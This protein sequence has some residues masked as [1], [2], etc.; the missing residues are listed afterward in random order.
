M[1]IRTYFDKDNTLIYSDRTNTGKNPVAELFYGGASGNTLYSRHIFYFDE[2]RLKSLVNDGTIIPSATTH[3][4]KM[5]NTASFDTRLLGKTAVGEKRRASSFDLILFQVNDYWDE[6]IGYD[7]GKNSYLGDLPILSVSPSNWVE[8]TTNANWSPIGNGS[9]ITGNT[10][11]N[12]L[13]IQHFDNGN[14]NLEMDVTFVVNH[15]LTGATSGSTG[16]TVSGVTVS[17]KNN[18]FAIAYKR[19]IEILSRDELQYV[20]FFTKQTDTFFEPYLESSFNN[21]IR[22]D[23]NQFFLDKTNSLYLYTSL[24][25]TPVNL[26]SNP[27]VEVSDNY[28][29]LISAFTQSA[30]TRVSKGVYKIDINIPSSTANT[31]CLMYSDVWKNIVINGVSRPDIELYFITKDS[32]LYY[33]FGDTPSDTQEYG[34]SISGIK[35]D[36]RVKRGDIRKITVNTRKAFTVNQNVIL[37]SIQYRLYVKEGK[38]EITVIDWEEVERANNTN[39]FLLDTYSLVPQRY[40]IDIKVTDNLDVNTLKNVMVFDIVN[41]PIIRS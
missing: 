36:E 4:L 25:N 24:G 27:T 10:S 17:S 5:T 13:A 29:N 7:Y 31:E 35:R 23:R 22:D 21:H 37:N 1:L 18:G 30:V 40:Y 3:T 2:T 9:A 16:T 39:Y 26:D 41:E 20:G 38:G 32:N 8:P 6:G 15:I 34:V 14:E 11:S 19:D 33:N 12:I 28:G